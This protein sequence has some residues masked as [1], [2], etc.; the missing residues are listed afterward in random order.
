MWT[1]QAYIAL[2]IAEER[3]REA[4]NARLAALARLGRPKTTRSIRRSVAVGLA[5]ISSAAASATRRLDKRVADDLAER[6]GPEGLVAG[7]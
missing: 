4:S 5:S 2:Q 3:A 1:Y 7:H 6:L